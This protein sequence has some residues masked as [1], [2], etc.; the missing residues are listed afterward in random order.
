MRLIITRP[1]EDAVTL[2]AKLES[3][4][5]TAIPAPLLKIVARPGAY[6]P[7][8]AYQFI[9]ATSGNALKYFQIEDRLKNIPLLAVGPQ[10]LSAAQEMGFKFAEAHGGD[11]H[12]LAAHAASNFNPQ[13]G[14]V[15]YLSG[16]ETS[17]DLQ[18]LLMAAGFAVERVIVYDAVAQTP[19][20]IE[21][22][23]KGTDGILLYSPRSARIWC[24]LMLKSRLEKQAANPIYFCLSGN[25]AK[26]LP[27]HWQK[28]VAKTPDEAA[29][30]ALLD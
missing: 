16:A 1:E 23:L 22:A 3:R 20:D 9:C 19:N 5:H 7:P 29:M 27:G 17:A 14:P 8:L 24:D 26:I 6:V 25:V 11:V 21:T 2:K 30:L 10:S 28:R 4:G 18:T 12:G 13:K 15:L